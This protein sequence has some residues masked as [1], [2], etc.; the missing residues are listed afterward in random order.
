MQDAAGLV[1]YVGK[2]KNLRQRL[3]HYRV[4]NPDR[5]GRRQLR[6]LP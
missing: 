2:A 1:L 5:L 3:G 6:L 4:A